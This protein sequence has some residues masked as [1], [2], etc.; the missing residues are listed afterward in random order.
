MIILGVDPGTNVTGFGVVRWER[1]Q[2]IYVDSGVILLPDKATLFDKLADIYSELAAIIGRFRPHEFAIE[3][4]FYSRNVK[5]ALKLGH[6][7]GAAVLAA[8]HAGLNITEYTPKEMKLAIVGN[9]SADK[10][11]VQYMIR[12]LLKIE[13]AMALDES[14]ALGLA[15]CHAHRLRSPRRKVSS[16]K[17]FIKAHPN[18]VKT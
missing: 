1:N 2:L 3:N 11:Q 7:R 12:Q 16:W 17:E 4:I 14:D 9:G 18:R 5:S 8:L 6:A 15:V 10:E 13:K